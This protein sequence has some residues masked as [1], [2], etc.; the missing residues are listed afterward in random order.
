MTENHGVG[1]SIPPLGTKRT[2]DHFVEVTRCGSIRQAADRLN[3]AGSAVSRQIAKL[4]QYVGVPLFERYSGG[5]HLTSAGRLIAESLSRSDRDLD[6]VLSAVDDLRGLKSGNVTIST[7]EGMIDEFL[8]KVVAKFHAKY[9]GISFNVRVESALAVVEAI[10]GDLTD[11]GIG[12]NVPKRKNLTIV[13][14]HPQPILVVC[15]RD[16]PLAK[17]KRV[18]LE[19]LSDYAIALLDTNFSIRRLVDKGFAHARIN[20]HAFLITNSLL[21]LKSLVRHGNA[22]TLLPS[23]AVKAEY[24]RG[25]LAAIRTDSQILKSAHL[26]LCVHQSKQLSSAAEEFLGVVRAELNLL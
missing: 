25:E 3:V 22:V 21:M 2:F 26:D 16:H 1:G 12:F 24:D 18:S 17:K 7:V 9:P 8:P 19:I 14:Q 11:I 4:E 15:R 20:Y 10:S 5:M 13:A 23:Y 6:R